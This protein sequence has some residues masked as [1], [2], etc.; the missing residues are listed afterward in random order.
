MSGRIDA[1][2]GSS[3]K[4]GA[5]LADGQHVSAKG[6]GRCVSIAFRSRFDPARAARVV[7]MLRTS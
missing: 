1:P 5:R 2:T 3:V 6:Q 7:R 4:G